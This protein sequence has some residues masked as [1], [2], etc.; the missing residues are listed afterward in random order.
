MNQRSELLALLA[1]TLVIGG[2][3]ARETLP[4][5]PAVVSTCLLVV[6]GVIGIVSIVLWWR[7]QAQDPSTRALIERAG[8]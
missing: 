3:V 8:V 7:E 6:G 5:V 4:G 1:V 2:V